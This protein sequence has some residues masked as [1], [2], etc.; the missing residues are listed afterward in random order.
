MFTL[1]RWASAVIIALTLTCFALG[2]TQ[3]TTGVIRG[4]VIDPTGAV[5]AGADVAALNVNTQVESR[6]Q[7]DGDGRFAF[8]SLSPC[9]YSITSS[10]GGFS[11]V[12]QKDVDLT[13][14]QALNL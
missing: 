6:Q 13:V 10:K 9:R 1:W 3:I 14:G 2:Q 12:I 7:T 8:L 5:V 4:T 11:K